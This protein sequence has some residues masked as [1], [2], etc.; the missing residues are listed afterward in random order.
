MI[1]IERVYKMH[2]ID[3][4][5]VLIPTY[6]PDQKFI[7][8]VDELISKGISKILVVNDGSS[9]ENNHYFEQVDNYKEVIRINH[10]VNQGKGRGL[11]TG[12][13]YILEY[14]KD[15][16]GCVT[17]DSDGQ[18]LPKDIVSCALALIENPD[19]VILGVRD[20]DDPDVP[21]R[22]KFGN[23]VTRQVLNLLVGI[24][25][26]DTQT[27]LRA[28]SVD[29]MRKFMKI[30]GEKYEYEMNMLIETKEIDIDVTEVPI[31][32]VYIAENESSHFNPI[33]DSVKIYKVFFKY[34]GSSFS[35][36][37]LDI[38][39][40]A[41]SASFLSSVIPNSYILVST[42]I[43]RVI[44]MLFNY[45]INA[46]K[47]FGGKNQKE[48]A[49][50]RYLGLAIVQMFASAF[51]VYQISNSISVNETMIKVFVDIFL[52]FISFVIQREFVFVKEE[53]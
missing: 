16:L 13:N 3:N 8:L 22:S 10:M 30:N 1:E 44:S 21:F 4:V 41:I 49:F 29:N 19:E 12:F 18:H 7:E 23:K 48:G 46:D 52:F 20:F 28:L 35:S 39:M 6:E 34:I 36:S 33:L 37:I 24:K 38:G 26:S 31:S 45:K 17:V 11:K 50:Y 5:I 15:V 32:T 25:I 53:S 40:F 47:V 43:A 42:I 14:E 9:I 27:G 51:L 2:N